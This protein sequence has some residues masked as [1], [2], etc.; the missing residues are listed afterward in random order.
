MLLFIVKLPPPK[1]RWALFWRVC[2]WEGTTFRCLATIMG[3][4]LVSSLSSFHLHPCLCKFSVVLPLSLVLCHCHRPKNLYF[5]YMSSIILTQSLLVYLFLPIVF[6]NVLLYVLV[7]F[8]FPLSPPNI[9]CNSFASE[10]ERQRERD[11][12]R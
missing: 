4:R 6:S 11:R 2:S 1:M 9:F 8:Q 10:I 3:W 12:D 7:E 5:I